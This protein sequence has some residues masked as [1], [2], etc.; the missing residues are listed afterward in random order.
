M[1]HR[2][3]GDYLIDN[4]ARAAEDNLYRPVPG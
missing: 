2:D 4:G 1:V 3:T